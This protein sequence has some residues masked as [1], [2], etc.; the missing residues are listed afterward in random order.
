MKRIFSKAPTW[1]STLLVILWVIVLI[2][3]GAIVLLLLTARSAAQVTIIR[4][5][6]VVQPRVLLLRIVHPR[7]LMPRISP[8]GILPGRVLPG[9]ILPGRILAPRIGFPGLAPWDPWRLPG[10][11]PIPHAGHHRRR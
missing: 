5:A 6:Q 3:L 1:R 10:L 11:S 4:Q 7:L 9:G 8:W 2:I